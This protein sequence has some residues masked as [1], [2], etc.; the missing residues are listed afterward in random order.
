MPSSRFLRGPPA[1]YRRWKQ[2][3]GLG[4]PWAGKAKAGLTCH[5]A[6]RFRVS[7]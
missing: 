4:R 2:L 7:P 5:T 1:L 3:A 6:G